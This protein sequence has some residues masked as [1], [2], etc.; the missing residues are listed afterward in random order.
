[1]TTSPDVLVIGGGPGGYNAAFRA[2]DLGA[3]VTLVE[4]RPQLGGVCLHVGCIPSKALLHVGQFITEAR[5]MAARGV[6]FGEPAI[7][8]AQLNAFKNKTVQRL[9]QGLDG[10]AKKRGVRVVRGQARLLPGH[11]ARCARADGEEEDLRFDHVVVAAGSTPFRPPGFPEHP[12]VVDSTG[13]LALPFVP[14]RLLIVGCGAIGLETAC[15]YAPLGARVTLA[16][17][18][19]ELLAEVDA[20]L[21]KPL[22]RRLEALCED[23]RVGVKVSV[24]PDDDGV[25]ARFDDGREERFDLALCATGRRPN[26]MALDAP[27]A[28]L[29]LG[30][31]GHI[32]TDAQMRTAA[33]GVCAVGDVTGGPALAHRAARQGKVAAEVIAGRA[34][35]FDPAAVPAVIYTDPEL[36][37]IPGA[38]RDADTV[39]AGVFPWAA[40]GRAAGIGRAD[41]LTKILRDART[42]RIV[43]GGM[44]GPNAGELIA[45]LAHAMEMGADTED[46]ALTIFPH[47]TL[48][49]TVGLAAEVCERTATELYLG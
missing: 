14:A 49:E 46:L 40:S 33:P 2:A 35:A 16:E 11:R 18:G 10:L 19:D 37:W 45:L 21:K 27:A 24:A 5:A 23:I 12:R 39:E 28:G 32:E 15:I 1:M 44:T 26:T 22:L 31:D 13:A 47:P 34:S 30:A 8:L 42:G 38:A 29:P 48:S 9:A 36:A 6:A 3:R 4:S 20:E 17:A 7:D 43:G 25:A 41:G